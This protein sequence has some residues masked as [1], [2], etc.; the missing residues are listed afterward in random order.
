MLLCS[1]VPKKNINEFPTKWKTRV[2][3][4]LTPLVFSDKWKN[5]G[6]FPQRR[7]IQKVPFIVFR[8]LNFHWDCT[9]TMRISPCLVASGK[10]VSECVWRP[11]KKFQGK[12]FWTFKCTNVIHLYISWRPWLFPM[13]DE[14]FMCSKFLGISAPTDF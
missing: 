3:W 9:E 8:R 5:E 7:V 13:N 14:I 2:E 1:L 11:L 12:K 10:I 6:N 4:I